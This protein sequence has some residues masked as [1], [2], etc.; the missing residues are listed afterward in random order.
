[1][2]R[3]RIVSQDHNVFHPVHLEFGQLG[4]A[5]FANQPRLGLAVLQDELDFRGSKPPAYSYRDNTPSHRRW[6]MAADKP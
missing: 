3:I 4:S 2:F 5:V 1:M 6:Q